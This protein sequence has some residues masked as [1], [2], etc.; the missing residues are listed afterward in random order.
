MTSH[1]D[2]RTPV[3][4]LPPWTGRRASLTL[5]PFWITSPPR[6]LQLMSS[7]HLPRGPGVAIPSASRPRSASPGDLS[8]RHLSLYV[9]GSSRATA[10]MRVYAFENRLARIAARLSALTAA[11]A[12]CTRLHLRVSRPGSYDPEVHLGGCLSRTASAGRACCPRPSVRATTAREAAHRAFA[13]WCF[14]SLSSR[15]SADRRISTA[16]DR[17]ASRP[18]CCHSRS[19]SPAASHMLP[20]TGSSY[21]ETSS[22]TYHASLLH[23]FSDVSSSTGCRRWRHGGDPYGGQPPTSPSFDNVSRRRARLPHGLGLAVYGGISLL[24]DPSLLGT[25][26]EFR[27]RAATCDPPGVFRTLVPRSRSRTRLAVCAD[28]SRGAEENKK[29]DLR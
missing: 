24:K 9:P 18:A 22:D 8:H 20:N 14:G 16:T 26:D 21:F 13:A 25:Q 5:I 3:H 12:F 29:P 7:A 4:A 27:R 2:R 17:D 6:V 28:P 11:G 10:T 23:T 19:S 1:P 15:R